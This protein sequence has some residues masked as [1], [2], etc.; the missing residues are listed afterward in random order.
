MK[1]STPTD[2]KPSELILHIIRTVA[3][4]FPSNNMPENIKK[5]NFT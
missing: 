4:N 5:L 3:H 1:Y 2:Y